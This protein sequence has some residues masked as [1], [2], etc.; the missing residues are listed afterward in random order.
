[1]PRVT[2]LTAAYNRAELMR[3]T[4]DSVLS[5]DYPDFE[6]L[7]LDDGSP[8]HTIDVLKEYARTWYL[9]SRLQYG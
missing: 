2:V 7:V 8:D 1:M 5:Q 3:E 9:Q 4:L 6:Y